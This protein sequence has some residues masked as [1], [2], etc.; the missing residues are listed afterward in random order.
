MKRNEYRIEI[1]PE[2]DQILT[3]LSVH[4][5]LERGDTILLAIKLLKHAMEADR[6]VLEKD[7]IAHIVNLGAGPKE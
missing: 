6:I 3:N 5:E 4:Y 2:W 7:S 1:T